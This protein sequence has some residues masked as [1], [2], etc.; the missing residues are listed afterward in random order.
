MVRLPDRVPP[1][2]GR[3]PRLVRAAAAEVA[4]VPPLAR[5]TV[6]V[7]LAAVP[8]TFPVTLPVRLPVTG[9]LNW[10]AVRGPV[11]VPP[12]SGRAPGPARG[13]AA[14]VAPVPPLARATVPVT[15]AAVPET[16]QVTLPVRFPVT[17]PV[18]G[19]LNWVAV[20]GPVMVPPE[21]GR[22]PRLARAAAAVVAPV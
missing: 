4:P 10:V 2:A 18:T 6:P 17:L 14:V 13:A 21:S 8:E 19:P 9:P 7:T 12:E 20:R 16:L 11:G 5:A 3:A 15:L 22:A 1:A